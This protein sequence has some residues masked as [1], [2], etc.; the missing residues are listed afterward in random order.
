MI[1]TSDLCHVF[2]MHVFYMLFD[3]DIFLYL[4]I[5]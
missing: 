2:E 4:L 1:D 3:A 5:I